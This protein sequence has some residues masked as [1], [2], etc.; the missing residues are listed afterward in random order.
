MDPNTDPAAERDKPEET[1]SL[2]AVREQNEK[3][4]ETMK[5]VP[6]VRRTAARSRRLLSTD[7]L[8]VAIE[9]SMRR[10]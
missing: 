2:K 8:A 4:V 5:S 6:A 7:L 9:R 3:L 10:A 1:E